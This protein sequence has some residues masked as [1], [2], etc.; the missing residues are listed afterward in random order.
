MKTTIVCFKNKEIP[1]MGLDASE[2]VTS[3][4]CRYCTIDWDYELQDNGKI[5][6][7]KIQKCK[8]P[9]HKCDNKLKPCGFFNRITFYREMVE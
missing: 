1:V 6:V 2:A 9:E 5:K 3:L 8:F 7:T 4:L